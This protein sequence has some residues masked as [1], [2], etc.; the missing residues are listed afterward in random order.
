MTTK[1]ALPFAFAA[2]SLITVAC[3][4]STSSGSSTTSSSN[5]G[6]AET[7]HTCADLMAC[8]GKIMTTDGTQETCNMV[9][10]QY[11]NNDTDCNARYPAFADY[12]P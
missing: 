5:G 4:S 9:Y 11:K 3:G 7:M 8:C 2:V 12:C 1:L 10:Q 6:A